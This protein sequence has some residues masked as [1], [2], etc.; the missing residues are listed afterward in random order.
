MN[1]AEQSRREVEPARRHFHLRLPAGRTLGY[2]LIDQPLYSIKLNTGDNRADI[3][4]FVE[5]RANSER[6]PTVADFWD[7]RLRNALLHKQARSGTAPLS[8][9]E[10]DSIDEA[11]D[12]AV[13]IGIFKNDERRFAAQ[14]ERKPLVT[15]RSRAANRAAH[16]RRPG[17]CDLV[18]IGMFHKR[19][20][21]RTVAS[22]NVYHARGQSNLLADF[23]KC[24]G[25]QR[26]KLGRL[27]H[28]RVSRRQSGRD[29]PGHHKQWEIPGNNLSHDSTCRVVRKLLW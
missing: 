3:D 20:A 7:Q 23:G 13:Q 9:I 22:H 11:F 24:K 2:A 14:F 27:Q 16:F 10:P 26:R 12:G 17:E 5:W 21:S 6:A 4:S 25:R 15:L 29:L 8:L 1:V 18:H 28:D 19:F